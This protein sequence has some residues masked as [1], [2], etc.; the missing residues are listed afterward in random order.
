ML[1]RG[2]AII[3]RDDPFMVHRPALEPIRT[4]ST[5]EITTLYSSKRQEMDDPI[6]KSATLPNL[7]FS[8]PV[9]P[10]H[11]AR[12]FCQNDVSRNP[13]GDSHQN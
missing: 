4:S 13:R 12:R 8:T 1:S 3:A 11:E 9:R 2:T 5:L 7:Q 10:N 6:L